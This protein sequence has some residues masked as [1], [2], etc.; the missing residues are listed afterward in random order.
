MLG[1]TLIVL[2]FVIVII[3]ITGISIYNSLVIRKNQVNRSFSSVDVLLKKRCDLIPNL[4]AVVKQHMQFEQKTLAEITRLRSQ[5]MTGN[6]SQDRRLVLE[7]QISRTM[8][9]ILAM[10]ENY[11]ELKSDQHISQLLGTLTEVEEQ[12]SAARRFFNTAVTEY[13]NALEMFPSNII[14]NMMGYRIKDVFVATAAE[15]QNIDVDRIF[16][17]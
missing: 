5:V 14:A 2:L 8:G 15:R 16:I 3:G 9:N 10:I 7:N 4:V 13:N 12:I 11:P 6:L 1:I 17:N